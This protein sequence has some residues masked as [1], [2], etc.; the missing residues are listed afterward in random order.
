MIEQS[1]PN[2]SRLLNIDNL[3]LTPIVQKALSSHDTNI[4]NWGYEPVSGGFGGGIGNTYIY[5]FSGDAQIQGETKTWSIILK[6]VRPNPAEDP[7]STH[8]WKREVEI[9]QSR[10]LENLPGRFF[11]VRTFGVLEYPDEACWLWMEDVKADLSQPWPLEHYGRVARHL[12]QF[13]GGYLTTRPIPTAPWL[14]TGWLRKIAQT[15]ESYVPRIQSMLRDSVWGD[16]LPPDAEAQFLRFWDERDLFLNALDHLP[17]TFCHQDSVARNLFARRGADGD[18]DTIAI[19]WAYVGQAAI[20]MDTAVLLN[21]GVAFMEINAADF[22][23]L[24]L[25]MY[26]QYLAGLH[27]S[28]WVG[29]AR[30]ARLGFTIAFACKYIEG[31]MLASTFLIDP[32]QRIFTE[33]VFKHPYAEIIVQFGALFRFALAATDEARQIMKELEQ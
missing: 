15:A 33:Q 30:Q 11:S 7:A 9:Y 10:W 27:D 1:D 16:A 28:G 26:N 18:Y 14:S 25:L 32:D 8:Y 13:N 3:L 12:G 24:D 29:D 2:S 17:Q 21:I 4:F 19:D 31:L 5:R 22:P 23:E 20:G 6:I